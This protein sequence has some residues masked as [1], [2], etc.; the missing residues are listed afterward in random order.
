ML[1]H[2][3]L[4]RCP[5]KTTRTGGAARRIVGRSAPTASVQSAALWCACS[6]APPTIPHH[7]EYKPV[8]GPAK[9]VLRRNASLC[10]QLY[11]PVPVLFLHVKFMLGWEVT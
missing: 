9:Q 10:K 5:W 4:V 8:E 11:G 1:S 2:C 6:L 7:N 3:A